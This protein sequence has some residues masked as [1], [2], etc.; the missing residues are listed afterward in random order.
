[1]QK[2]A[3]LHPTP[4]FPGAVSANE[5]RVSQT[6]TD[7]RMLACIYFFCK[8]LGDSNIGAEPVII[9]SSSRRADRWL[10]MDKI[11]VHTRRRNPLTYTVRGQESSPIQTSI[12]AA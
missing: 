8:V 9:S 5:V 4:I 12:L 10:E 1:M 7:Q 6:M 11:D 3:E 2:V